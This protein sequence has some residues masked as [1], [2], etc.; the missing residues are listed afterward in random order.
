MHV[1]VC[2]WLRRRLSD[3]QQIHFEH[4]YRFNFNI[5]CYHQT[6]SPINP[7]LKLKCSRSAPAGDKLRVW[8][9]FSYKLCKLAGFQ[10]SSLESNL[11][12]G[13]FYLIVDRAAFWKICSRYKFSMPSTQSRLKFGSNTRSSREHTLQYFVC[14][15][16]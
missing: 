5:R 1:I 4:L 3:W 11:D 12:S 8:R 2:K 7:E 9:W 13:F 16:V 10:T 6:C 15:R 14:T